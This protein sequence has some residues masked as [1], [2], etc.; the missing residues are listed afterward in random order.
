MCK[1]TIDDK[2]KRLA[3]E[4]LEYIADL[5]YLEGWEDAM[6]D[7]EELMNLRAFSGDEWV[8][9]DESGNE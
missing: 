2:I 8:W 3:R 4:R 5:N 7:A 9:V 6:A 1:E